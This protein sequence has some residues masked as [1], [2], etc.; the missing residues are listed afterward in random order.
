MYRGTPVI[1]I[2]FTDYDE[3]A[4]HSGPERP[5]ALDALDGVDKAIGTLQKASEDA[6]RP[7]RFIVLSD[8]GQT[9]GSTFRQRFGASLEDVVRGL[10]GGRMAVEAATSRVE[11]W[12]QL[13]AFVDEL[14]RAR[15][16]TGALARA[17]TGG[18]GE[19]TF[20]PSESTTAMGPP[21]GSTSDTD[22]GHA[23]PGHLPGAIPEVVVCASGN[24]GLISFPP[25]PG[26]MT[27]EAIDA[28][29]PGLLDALANHPGIGFVMVATDDRG[30]I[31]IGRDGVRF[32]ADDTVQG[33]DP[34][35]PYGE[36]APTGLRRVDGMATAPDILA[37][38]IYDTESDE[39]AAFEELIGSHGGLGGPQTRAFVLYPADWP[40][41]DGP[42]VGAPAVYT[43]LRRWMEEQLG[44]EVAP[45]RATPA[46]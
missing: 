20:G 30:A 45:A 32:L 37:I 35:A 28:R 26:R 34:L 39:V 18:R 41:P 23:L 43:Q 38:S 29:N 13:N 1:Y 42:I 12:G 10:L 5:D 31:C 9:L 7:Y 46:S 2:D 36:Y 14:K 8:H 16:M 19:R 21:V 40:L 27:F 4:H 22:H 25:V 17:V 44:L 11:E 33:K 24:L 3:I 15:G 6:S